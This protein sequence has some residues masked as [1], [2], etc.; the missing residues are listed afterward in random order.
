MG[1]LP[2]YVYSNELSLVCHG[3]A[4]AIELA[5]TKYLNSLDKSSNE[6]KY[7]SKIPFSPLVYT[8]GGSFMYTMKVFFPWLAPK[9]L[10][11]LVELVAYNK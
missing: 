3:L 5:W 7:I 8:F 1:G 4:S 6:Y 11:R 10:N 9:F 2:F